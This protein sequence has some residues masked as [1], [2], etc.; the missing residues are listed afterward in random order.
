M[1]KSRRK[2]WTGE[3]TRMGEKKNAYRILMGKPE[4]RRPLGR[5]RCR[6]V[7]IIKIDL[8]KRGWDGMEWNYLAQVRDQWNALV[9]TVLNFRVP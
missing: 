2:R 9:N 7:D 1:I 3:V 6:W 5:P 4:G 8:T